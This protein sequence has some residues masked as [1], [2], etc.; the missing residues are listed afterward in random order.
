MLEIEPDS[1]SGHF[2]LVSAFVYKGQYPEAVETIR[3]QMRKSGTKEEVIKSL[4]SGDAREVILAGHREYVNG[5]QEALAK[6]R[7]ISATYLASVY[8]DLGEN[9]QAFA[10]LEKAF[11]AR[12]P[13]FIF[14]KI[15]PAYG[16]LHADPRF[17]DL[18]RRA[19]LTR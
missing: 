14:F 17:A 11:S 3:Q 16:N 1:P 5:M 2:C 15:H 8:A 19:N 18:A 7:K 9:D 10:W 12:E 6:R 4:T 13:M